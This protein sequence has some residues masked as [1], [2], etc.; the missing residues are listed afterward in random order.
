MVMD[1][2]TSVG[3]GSRGWGRTRHAEA[4]ARWAPRRDPDDATRGVGQREIDHRDL[5]HHRHGVIKFTRG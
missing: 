3:E 4:L 1:D 2:P 5:H